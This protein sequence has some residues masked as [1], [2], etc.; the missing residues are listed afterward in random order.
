M[1]AL[2]FTK[3]ES[4]M[5]KEKKSFL[6]YLDYEEHFNLLTDEQLGKLIR[7]MMEYEKT[8]KVPEIN[9]MIKM[10]FS[11]IK[12]QLDR[13]RGKYEEKCAKNKENGKKGGRPKQ[14]QTV[15]VK[16]ERFSRKPN[17]SQKTR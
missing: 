15:I 8:K 16:T 17:K 1:L 13:D 7:V 5:D 2:D 14:N 10:A 3:G 11:F 6:V 4:I 9:G 12:A